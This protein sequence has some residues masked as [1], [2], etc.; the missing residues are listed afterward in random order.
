VGPAGTTRRINA[1]RNV[2]F[3]ATCRGCPLRARCTTKE[4]GRALILRKHDALLRA[5]RSNWATHP[6]LR[7]DYQEYRP[8]IE[9]VISQ[10]ASRG[11]RR[12]KL[13]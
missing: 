2:T 11:G 1:R 8:N 12:L 3:H 4:H 5:A 7:G 10:V 9:P 6:A 13:R